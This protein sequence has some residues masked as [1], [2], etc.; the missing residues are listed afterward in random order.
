MRLQAYLEAVDLARRGVH[1]GLWHGAFFPDPY[2]KTLTT[3]PV[4]AVL[5]GCDLLFVDVDDTLLRHD[6][7]LTAARWPAVLAAARAAGTY[8][9]VVS[10]RMPA[11]HA[12]AVEALAAAGLAYDRL[13][14]SNGDLKT[15]TYTSILAERA[16]ARVVVVDDNTSVLLWAARALL[17][18]P[19]DVYLFRWVYRIAD[20]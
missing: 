7:T 11:D 5:P 15:D 13:V 9:C 16:V 3:A 8:V 2:T 20:H 18:L 19:V 4:E 14:F 10:S 6:G 17:C 1:A 12:S